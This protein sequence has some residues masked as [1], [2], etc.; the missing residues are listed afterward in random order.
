MRVTLYGLEKCSTCQK[1]RK[2]L[3]RHKTE[4][5]FIDYREQRPA[6]EML[7]TKDFATYTEAESVLAREL[8]ARLARRGP[9]R[10]SRRTRPAGRRRGHA[11]DLRR[12]VR[13]SLRTSGEPVRRQPLPQSARSSS[14]TVDG[15]WMT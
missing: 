13:G 12:V 15:S 5:D 10:A 2:W 9:M 3:Q 8:I 11:P 6:P 14:R 1:A 7:R 4:H